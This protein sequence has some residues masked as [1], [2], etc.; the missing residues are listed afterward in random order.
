M[1]RMPRN[2]N[3]DKLSNY[4]INFNGSTD[5]I[6]CGSPSLFDD[7]T[8]FS[9]SCW[10]N[11]DLKSQDRGILGKWLSG[12]DRSFALNLETS[13]NIRFVVR[14]SS[15]TAVSTYINTS[16]WST[17]N[18]YNV[19]GVYDGTNVKVYLDGVLKDTASLTG[20]VLNTTHPFRIGKYHSTTATFSGK[21]SQVCFFDYTLSTDQRNYLYNLNNPMAITGAEPVAY[22]PLGD[23]SNPNS[24]A[25]YPNISVGADSVF[26][27][28][29]ND[30]VNTNFQI[31]TETAYSFSAWFKIASAPA[32]D[33]IILADA[34]SAGQSRSQRAQ[35]GFYQNF[36]FAIM[37]NGSSSW[38]D[39]SSY[40]ISAAYD[41]NWHNITLAINGTSQKLYLDGSLVRTYTSSISA[42]T[43]GTQNYTI[44]R[45]GDYNGH[46]FE[47]ELSNV[48]IWDTEL[49]ASEVTTLYNSGVPLTGTQPQE[50]NL[51]AWY[52]LDQ[53]ANWEADS[54]GNWQI[55]DAVSA[56][57]QSFD[58][59]GSN[60]FINTN[61][62]VDNYT[63]LTYSVWVN[64]TSLN[65]QSG[66]A[67]TSTV[68]NFGFYF[69][70]GSGGRFYVKI[71]SA[72][73]QIAGTWSLGKFGTLGEEKW[74]HIAIVYDGNG[75]T[76]ADRLKVYADGNYV[77]FTT[78]G[79]IP[80]S[81][82]SGS[83]DLIIGKY[84]TYEWDGK[85]SNVMLFN[86]SLPATGADSVETLYNNGVPLTTAIATDNLKA[87]YKLDNTETYLKPD[88]SQTQNLYEAWLVENQKYPASVDKC[89]LFANNNAIT[90][91]NFNLINEPEL[92]VSFW[93]LHDNSIN[94]FDRV[95]GSR[96][97]VAYNF[98]VNVSRSG[99]PNVSILLRTNDGAGGF[100]NNNL[101][102]GNISTPTVGWRL[103]TV[104]YNGSVIKAY[105]NN[106]EVDSLSATGTVYDL[107]P[108]IGGSRNYNQSIR[109]GNGS[110]NG[111][112]MSNVIYWNKALTPS[113][114]TTLYNN[115]TPLLT[116]ESIP[117]NS[118]MLLWN[119]L[120]NKTETIGGGLYDKSGNSVSIQSIAN[121]STIIVDNVPVS[122]ESALSSGM[123]EQNLVNNNVS[124][125][126]GESVGMNTTNLVT[127]NLT[128]TQP[129]SNYSF[130]FDSAQSDYFDCGN[131]TSLNWGTGNGSVSCWFKTTQ[132]VVSVADLVINGGFSTGG[133]AYILYLDSSEKV[134]FALDDNSSPTT[135]AQSSGSVADGNW[136]HVVGVRESGNIKLYLDGS[137]VSTQT[138]TTGN[139]DS[140]DPLIIGAGMNASTGVV[141]NFYN[142]EISNVA[143]WDSALSSDDIINL[144]NNGITQD[145]N[146]FRITPM[147][148][149]PLDEHSSYY[150]GTDWVVRDLENSNDGQ[151]AN[152]GNVDDLVGNAPGSEASGTGTNLTIADLKGNM[153]SS[154]KNAYS[155]NMGDYADGV[156]NPANS[157][158]ST[159]V[160]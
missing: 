101:Y 63:N 60:D 15:Q 108:Y 34:N 56:Y 72:I 147:A 3:K 14:N 154:D 84:S 107:N 159:N 1:W 73:G 125:L 16:D 144:Y 23:N 121:S 139:I 83:G 131:D 49:L 36:F 66:L 22:W 85:M 151:G 2:T 102:F 25:G 109:D 126:N 35:L 123:T 61:L 129:Y 156:T 120:E 140:T 90:Y 75:A 46:Y 33:S 82:P 79:S 119:T 4:S 88:A 112:R 122:A 111:M 78:L 20:T 86:S 124:V 42:G 76:D 29:G 6:D 65:Q 71:G 153:S 40:N 31:G 39:L 116:K 19:I 81:I 133:K 44:G 130:N 70:S 95:L 41:N 32:A 68:D 52:K 113:E 100:V 132:N 47:G 87:W 27:F 148:W 128:R 143:I 141:G 150:D 115:G 30:Y 98:Y 158:R 21:I 48:Q 45:Y 24:N 62:N 92:T 13:G 50:A 136:H 54:S 58:F 69:W 146:N 105:V 43:A 103:L 114:L 37:G 28:D 7:L 77:A 64:P 99:A 18:W 26:E 117:Q 152:T 51:K 157:G 135:P 80:T 160:P 155:I 138:D 110:A 38:Y 89:L 67:Y 118:S 17:G 145:L 104:T 74:L 97:N 59:D 134:G 96:D 11:S 142:G 8:S 127:S 137:L 10:F 53:S 93:Y 91:D 55:P 94:S 149:W 9:F 5:Y 57:P 106:E 12:T